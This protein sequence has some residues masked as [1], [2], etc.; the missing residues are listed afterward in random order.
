MARVYGEDG[1]LLGEYLIADTG[2][3]G[4]GVRAGTTVDIW[5]PTRE[6]CKALTQNGYIEIIE[7]TE[8]AAAGTT[9]AH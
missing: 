8:T 6:E 5:K 3:K 1:E 4:G 9:A 2:K 7:K